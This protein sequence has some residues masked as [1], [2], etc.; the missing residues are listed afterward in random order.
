MA[1]PARRR[2]RR[3]LKAGVAWVV[4]CVGRGGRRYSGQCAADMGHFAAVPARLQ[5]LCLLMTRIAGVV[6]CVG[7]DGRG[8]RRLWAADMGHLVVADPAR[9]WVSR[10]RLAGT[11]RGMK[12]VDRGGRRHGRC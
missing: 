2:T 11:A 5:E 3:R 1:V 7:R 10:K 8:H 12:C 9:N 4:E 6:Q